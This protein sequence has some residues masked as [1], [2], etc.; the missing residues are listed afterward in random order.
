MR[1]FALLAALLVSLNLI[2]A[3]DEAAAKQEESNVPFS[4]FVRRTRRTF[5]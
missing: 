5:R 2:Q 1:I 4:M 3:Q